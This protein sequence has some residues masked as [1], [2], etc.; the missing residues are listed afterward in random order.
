M[1]HAKAACGTSSVGFASLRVPKVSTSD[2]EIVIDMVGWDSLPTWRDGSDLKPPSMPF[3][4]GEPLTSLGMGLNAHTETNR[5][6]TTGRAYRE[7]TLELNL[8]LICDHSERRK[9]I[10]VSS[11]HSLL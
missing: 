5:A 11:G 3:I 1:S 4:T 9:R 2:E 8:D 7:P 6:R 10:G